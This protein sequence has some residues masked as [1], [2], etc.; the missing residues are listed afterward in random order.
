[1]PST[2]RVHKT[3]YWCLAALAGVLAMG[4]CG[5]S[6]QPQYGTKKSDWAKTTPPPNWRGPGQPGGP[7][8]AALNGPASQPPAGAANQPQTR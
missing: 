4:M 1:M 3:R 7:P 8:A 2:Y 6:S 5:C